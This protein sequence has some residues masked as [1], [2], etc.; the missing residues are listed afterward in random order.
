MDKSYM[1]ALEVTPNDSEDL[2]YGSCKAL[3]I[4][5]AGN[6][7]VTLLNMEDGESVLLTG[8]QAGQVIKVKAKRIWSASTTATDIVALY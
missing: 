4:G 1:N 3:L 7:N 8:L 6:V 2:S 5:G